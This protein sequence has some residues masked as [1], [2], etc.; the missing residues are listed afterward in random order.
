MNIPVTRPRNILTLEKSTAR[1]AYQL[2]KLRDPSI[3][4]LDEWLA[5][6]EGPMPPLST[7]PGLGSSNTTAPSQAA[8][9]AYIDAETSRAGAAEAALAA[10]IELEAQ[11]RE[12]EVGPLITEVSRITALL[13]SD[14]VSLDDLQEIVT[15]IKGNKT[16]LDSLGIAGVIGLQDAL[17]ALGL[18]TTAAL[19]MAATALNTANDA[20]SSVAVRVSPDEPA[21][22]RCLWIQIDAQGNPISLWLK[23]DS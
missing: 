10:A 3:G 4:T 13:T 6:L 20:V 1:D 23:T 12:L 21:D 18:A 7:D 15:F 22:A 14:D 2:A 11:V 5:S 16:L 17:D 19:E 9:K 8:V